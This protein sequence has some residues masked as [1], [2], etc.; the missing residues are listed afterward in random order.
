MVAGAALSF[1]QAGLGPSEVGLGGLGR[2]PLPH[3]IA[4]SLLI[5]AWGWEGSRWAQ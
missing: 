5:G 4:P 3:I 1:L 2:H